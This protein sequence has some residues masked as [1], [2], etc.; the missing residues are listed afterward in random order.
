MPDGRGYVICAPHEG[1]KELF[2]LDAAG[3]IVRQLTDNDVEDC[4]PDV[5]PDGETVV[6]WSTRSGS[7]ELWSMALDGSERPRPLTGF[8]GNDRV[9]R[10]RYGGEGPPCI[11]P[12]GKRIA[13]MSIRAGEDWDVYT[14]RLDGTDVRRL[15]DH[16]ADDDYPRLV[17][18]RPLYRLRF[19]SPWQL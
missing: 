5:T 14:M 16:L 12:D 4:Q 8:A 1:D 3:R 11:S 10:H 6:F 2:L 17:T 7:A 13:W 9:P 15:T 19:K 18:G